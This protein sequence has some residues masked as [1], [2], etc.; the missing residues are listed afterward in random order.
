MASRGLSGIDHCGNLRPKETSA[1]T[2]EWLPACAVRSTAAQSA[3]AN[4]LATARVFSFDEM[5]AKT[6]PNGSVG[7]NVFT[8]TLATGEAV[9]VHEIMQAAGTV[10]SPAHRI[11]LSEVIVVE[12]G[13]FEFDH[14]GKAGRA[15]AGS[16]IYVAFGTQRAVKNVGAGPV[17]YIVIQ[18]GGDTRK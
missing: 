14:D 15:G 11:Q 8:G 3:G 10:A 5:T 7:R 2:T 9:A 6:A 1:S 18:I 16:I 17:K 4:S 13:A 12:E